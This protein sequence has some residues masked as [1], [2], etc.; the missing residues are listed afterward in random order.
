MQ[1]IEEQKAEI[2]RRKQLYAEHKALRR[3]ALFEVVACAACVLL[4]VAA[5][6]LIPNLDKASGEVEVK[7]YGSLILSVPAMGYVVFGILAFG[8]GILATL[9]CRDLLL[10][11]R[12]KAAV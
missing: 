6:V 2:K 11:R 8:L 12:R 5:S 9:L 7:Q 3:R 10:I 1:S 4:I